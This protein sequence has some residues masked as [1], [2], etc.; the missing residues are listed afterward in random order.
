MD[1][2]LKRLISNQ[3]RLQG[4]DTRVIFEFAGDTVVRVSVC[5]VKENNT[6]AI[7]CADLKASLVDT[8]SARLQLVRTSPGETETMVETS[9]AS[10]TAQRM[11]EFRRTPG[12][13]PLY[14]TVELGTESKIFQLADAEVIL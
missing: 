8:A 4:K 2:E 10:T 1:G 5:I 7:K 9:S 13:N 14:A 6:A 11:F 3:Q 12:Q